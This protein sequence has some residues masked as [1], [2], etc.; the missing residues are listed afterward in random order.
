MTLTVYSFILTTFSNLFNIQTSF[1][2]SLNISHRKI[3]GLLS[4]PTETGSWNK[5]HETKT[6][7]GSLSTY[8][9]STETIFILTFFFPAFEE[10]SRCVLAQMLSLHLLFG[11][12]LLTLRSKCSLI[13]GFPSLFFFC[14]LLS[15]FYTFLFYL[16]TILKVAC[17]S[18]LR[19]Y[20][21]HPNTTHTVAAL[22]GDSSKS[23][24]SCYYISN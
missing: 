15:L 12:S 14:Q 3:S 24:A 2:C 23:A 16:S 13:L 20:I 7:L 11:M 17:M 8:L 19:L 10:S 6:P 21:T 5:R 1:F 9:V 4:S 22:K 18:F